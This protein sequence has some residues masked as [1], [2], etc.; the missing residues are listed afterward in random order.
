M[1]FTF[2]LYQKL[3]QAWREAMAANK[4]VFEFEGQLFDVDYA[5]YLLE[6]LAWKWGN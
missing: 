4:Q 1:I 2:E 3:G 5:K 6:Y